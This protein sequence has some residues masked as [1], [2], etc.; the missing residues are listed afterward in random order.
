MGVVVLPRE[1]RNALIARL[2]LSSWAR[3]TMQSNKPRVALLA[4][5]SVG[6]CCPLLANRAVAWIWVLL[7]RAIRNKSGVLLGVDVGNIA[8]GDECAEVANVHHI[9]QRLYR[10]VHGKRR[11]IFTRNT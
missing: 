2:N 5:A 11:I 9:H 10:R 1:A 8:L 4:K 6:I 3:G 7:E